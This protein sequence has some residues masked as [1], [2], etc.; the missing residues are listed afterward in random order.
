M[1]EVSIAEKRHRSADGESIVAVRDLA[2]KVDAGEF[3]CLIGPSGCGK[4]TTLRILAGLD[5]DFEGEVL[6]D[7]APPS[8]AERLGMVFQEPRLLPWRSV[9]QNVRLGLPASER[10]RPLDKLFERLDLAEMRQRY[11]DELSLGLAR[12]AAL[13]RALAIEPKFL[14]LD[15]PLTSL[16]EQTAGRLRRLLVDLWIE[17]P[18]TALMVTHNLAEAVAVADRLIFL[19]PRP[20][21]VLEEIRLT[22]PR[23]ARNAEEIA[24][25]VAKLV[26]ELPGLA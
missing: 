2:F 4:T 8:T 15:E 19:T 10:M 25:I 16:D 13:A 5:G 9:E 23:N 20:A 22:T 7:G 17:T 24:R 3:V 11:P 21:S 18:R 1:L 14:L 6:I 26:A 12:R